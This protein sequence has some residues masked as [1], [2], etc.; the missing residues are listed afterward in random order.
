MNG[1]PQKHHPM[2]KQADTEEYVRLIPFTG[3][4]Q[5]ARVSAGDRRQ[6]RGYLPGSS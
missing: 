3:S 5:L 2:G 6:N 1:R 4:E